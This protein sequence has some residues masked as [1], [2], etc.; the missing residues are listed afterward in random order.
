MLNQGWHALAL[1]TDRP[2]HW[3][4]RC[5]V[6][7]VFTCL[8]LF[9][10][11]PTVY[12]SIRTRLSGA[13]CSPTPP[14]EQ[15]TLHVMCCY[16]ILVWCTVTYAT[17]QG[18][19]NSWILIGREMSEVT[20]CL[21]RVLNVMLTQLLMP[22]TCSF[23]L[24][25]HCMCVSFCPWVVNA[26][27]RMLSLVLKV[28]LWLVYM[29]MATVAFRICVLL[30]LWHTHTHTHTLYYPSLMCIQTSP[31]YFSFTA[32]VRLAVTLK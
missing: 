21:C 2:A 11:F 10:I 7:V 22:C 3:L 24:C 9:F 15:E 13:F 26:L 27:F 29:P 25:A 16:C 12:S 28:V 4:G 6:T 31:F 23:R 17:V 14:G 30:L 5:N 32:D 20:H 18:K 1:W 8:C 19:A